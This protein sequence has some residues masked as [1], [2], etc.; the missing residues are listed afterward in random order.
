[1]KVQKRKKAKLALLKS[2]SDAALL[3]D[4][5]TPENVGWW[6]EHRRAQALTEALTR[7]RSAAE[8]LRGTDPLAPPKG[9]MPRVV[10]FESVLRHLAR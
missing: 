4:M 1:M 6:V 3:S 2:Y 8:W 5:L 7:I 10:D 9:P